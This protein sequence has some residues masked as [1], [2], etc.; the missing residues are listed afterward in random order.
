[1]NEKVQGGDVLLPLLRNLLKDSS[2]KNLLV[3]LVFRI[4]HFCKLFHL[5]HHFIIAPIP[6][7]NARSLFVD[8]VQ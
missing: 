2:L 8:A 1:M 6:W 5:R 4:A 7:Y 3:K